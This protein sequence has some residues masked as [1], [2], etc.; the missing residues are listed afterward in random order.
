MSDRLTWRQQSP[1]FGDEVGDEADGDADEGE[2]HAEGAVA[3]GQPA[4]HV[5]GRR[6]DE[7]EPGKY[8]PVHEPGQQERS[9]M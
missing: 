3:A 8:L 4:G 6:D 9:G 2:A 7:P 1:E 5:G